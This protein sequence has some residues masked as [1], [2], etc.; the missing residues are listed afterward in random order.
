MNQKS[1][2]GKKTKEKIY[3][4]ALK[5]INEKGYNNVT[6]DSICQKAGIAKGTFYV[7]FQAK[8]DIIRSIYKDNARKF[9]NDKMGL[10]KNDIQ[11]TLEE[12]FEYCTLSL[13]YAEEIELDLT[14][15]SYST[16]LSP[17]S[18]QRNFYEEGYPA[19]T[20]MEIVNKC[21]QNQLFKEQYTVEMIIK[22][23]LIVING[24]VVNWCLDNG[25]YPLK[26]TSVP[27]FHYLI[28]DKYKK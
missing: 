23:L 4:T 1:I 15:L 3:A 5:L 22:E 19:N 11:G 2:Q 16:H 28:Y 21:S 26:E 20:L 9:V 27:I 25:M 6:V 12:L 13:S 8:D 14:A 24:S 18:K 7:H 10:E 17:F